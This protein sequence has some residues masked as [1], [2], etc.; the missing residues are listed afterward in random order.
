VTG[1]LAYIFL[2][3]AILVPTGDKVPF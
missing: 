2:Q 1:M 3:F